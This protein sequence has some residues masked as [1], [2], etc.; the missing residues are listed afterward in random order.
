MRRAKPIR[1][2]AVTSLHALHW[3]CSNSSGSS[4]SSRNRVRGII[5]RLKR[6]KKEKTIDEKEARC[7]YQPA[8]AKSP[9]PI[10]EVAQSVHEGV[11]D[12]HRLEN[13]WAWSVMW[14][15]YFS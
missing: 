1:Y 14:T 15:V 12:C 10:S 8:T 4:S 6:K 2:N 5:L 3:M 9:E 11:A 7:A 13:E